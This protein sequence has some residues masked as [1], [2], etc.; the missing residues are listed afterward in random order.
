MPLLSKLSNKI[1]EKYPTY[2][3]NPYNLLHHFALPP[4]NFTAKHGKKNEKEK[5]GDL[6]QHK[7]IMKNEALEQTK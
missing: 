2:L 1:L 4:N 3:A 6:S 7:S 5:Y